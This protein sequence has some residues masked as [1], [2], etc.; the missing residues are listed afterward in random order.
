MKKTLLILLILLALLF[1]IPAFAEEA[2]EIPAEGSTVTLAV[3][4]Q[5]L[6]VPADSE[7]VDLGTIALN[8][9]D[10][11]AFKALEAFMS[12]LP[13]LKKLDMYAT[14]IRRGRI[15]HLAAAFPQVEFGWTMV[16]EPCSNKLHPERRRLHL[17]RADD[18]AFSTLHNKYCTGHT[19]LDFSVLKYCRNLQALDIGH[20]KVTDL[21]FLYDL[22]HLKVLI[23]ALNNISD[24]TPI[25]S[26]KELEYLEIFRNYITDISPLANCKNLV[27]LNLCNNTISDYSPLLELKHLR[28][29]WL[30]RS[31]NY[32]NVPLPS[33]TVDKLQAAL[34]DCLINTTSTG[35]EG[36]WRN[37]VRFEE[38][39]SKIF[40]FGNQHYIP[41]Q[42]LE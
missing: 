12:S 1:C 8:N 26:L 23:L 29:L 38:G 4:K 17:V 24:I 30:A 2:A 40:E 28:R 3:G 18:T 22:P 34:P 9:G 36:G 21:S 5:T 37:H 41:F 6:T 15:A 14:E 25:G 11:K 32:G 27:D 19:D 16:I 20:N 42:T 35:T 13:N 10:E 31:N 39:I 33:G 7:Y